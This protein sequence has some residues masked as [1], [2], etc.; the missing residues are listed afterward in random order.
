[1]FL[2]QTAFNGL[3]RY[4]TKGNFNSAWG[5]QTTGSHKNFFAFNKDALLQLATIL[6]D[7]V[8]FTC[9]SY[10]NSNYKA[11]DFGF[12]DP[13]YV[14]LDKRKIDTLAYCKDGFDVDEQIK[15]AN[16]CQE[17]SADKVLLMVCN[18]QNDFIEEKYSNFKFIPFALTKIFSGAVSA[19][20]KTPE[21]LMCNY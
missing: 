2:C 18:H 9:C 20:K 5:T 11:G 15:F 14:A 1:M 13:P 8:F 12:F 10:E 6:Q 4:N 19:R 3:V 21:V 17:K 7:N 16:W